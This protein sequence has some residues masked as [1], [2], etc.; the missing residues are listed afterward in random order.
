M[1]TSSFTGGLLSPGW[2]RGYSTPGEASSALA[3]AGVLAP[4]GH[5]RRARARDQ[6]L[7][8]V[9]DVALDETDGSA[10]LH[11]PPRGDERAGPDGLQE[12]DLEL[13]GGERL[14]LVEGRGPRHAH[15]RV[16][17]VAEDA[18]MERAHRIRV[19]LPRLELDHGVTGLD[20]GQLEADERG[21]RRRRKL[22]T[23]YLAYE[24]EHRGHRSIPPHPPRA[25]GDRDGDRDPEERERQRHHGKERREPATKPVQCREAARRGDDQARQAG[26]DR[27]EEPARPL[28]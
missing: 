26:E 12:V 6:P 28:R 8:L 13:E 18:A 7:F 23:L 27:P 22:A 25:P 11:D 10:A 21:D 24:V 3:A 16:R 2:T 19:A 1:P 9:D 5:D 20:G 15:R 4:Q 14:T 17:D